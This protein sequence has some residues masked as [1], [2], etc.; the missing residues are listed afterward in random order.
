M[1]PLLLS[2]T[3]ILAYFLGGTYLPEICCRAFLKQE[4]RAYGRGQKG[5]EALLRETGWKGAAEVFLPEALKIGLVVLIGGWLLGIKGYPVIGRMFALFCLTMGAVYPALRGFS[6]G[7]G[8]MEVCVGMMFVDPKA[9][10]VTLAVFAIALVAS[11]YLS[12]GGIC[13]GAGAVLGTWVFIEDK[14]CMLMSALCAAII[15]LRHIGNIGRMIKH[16]EPKIS[17]KKDLSYKFDE[18]F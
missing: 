13:A 12:L 14:L 1:I 17:T 10:F 11:K 5:F 4:L 3:A 7:R 2:L 6:G 16:T 15:L 9:G 18:D 8:I